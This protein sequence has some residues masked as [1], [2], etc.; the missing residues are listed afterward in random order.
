HHRAGEGI[1]GEDGRAIADQ[2]HEL[3]VVPAER[4]PRRHRAQASERDRL[5]LGAGGGVELD[6]RV[7]DR[8]VAEDLRVLEGGRGARSAVDAAER[9]D[10]TGWRRRRAGS[11]S[12]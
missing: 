11:H 7:G 5:E 2:D 12:D 8:V 6:Q 9:E 1:E 10:Y 3:T 4:N